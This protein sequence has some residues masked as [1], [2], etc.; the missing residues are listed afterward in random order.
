MKLVSTSTWECQVHVPAMTRR[1]EGNG[2]E[3]RGSGVLQEVDILEVR[4]SGCKAKTAWVQVLAIPRAAFSLSVPRH[5]PLCNGAL[6]SFNTTWLM[7][8]DIGTQCTGHSPFPAVL[9]QSQGHPPVI[10]TSTAL[11]LSSSLTQELTAF[12]RE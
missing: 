9:G 8:E 12:L 1:Y 2:R 5:L 3:W 11:P 4:A 7:R 6:K 10:T